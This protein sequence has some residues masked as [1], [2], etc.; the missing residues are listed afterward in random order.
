MSEIISILKDLLSQQERLT[1]INKEAKE[2]KQKINNHK[3]SAKLFMVENKSKVLDCGTHEVNLKKKSKKPTLSTKNQVKWLEEYC[4]TA[5]L[6]PAHAQRICDFFQAKIA[7]GTTESDYVSVTKAKAKKKRKKKKK[8]DEVQ[9]EEEDDVPTPKKAKVEPV[10][11]EESQE[12]EID[13]L[14]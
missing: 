11:V 6:D 8:E 7:E 13:A 10:T 1:A 12:A 14:F 9:D 3:E 2:I 4:D 5:D